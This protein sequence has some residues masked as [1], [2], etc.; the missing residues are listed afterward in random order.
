M[1]AVS[2]S[3][4]PG[5]NVGVRRGLSADIKKMQFHESIGHGSLFYTEFN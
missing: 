1:A 2:G 4:D 3:P 5:V